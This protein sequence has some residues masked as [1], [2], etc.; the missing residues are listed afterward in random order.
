MNSDFFTKH[1][2]EKVGGVS[3]HFCSLQHKLWDLNCGYWEI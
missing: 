1:L 2:R 3:I